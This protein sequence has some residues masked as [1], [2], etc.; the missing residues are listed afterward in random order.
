MLSKRARSAIEDGSNDVL[1]SAAVA[2]EI[3]IKH[4]LGK[5]SLPLD[6]IAYFP[7]RLSALGFQALAITADHAL[8]VGKLPPYHND[9]FDRIMIAQ[10]QMEGLTFVT[11]DPIAATYR[12]KTLAAV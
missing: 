4:A 12:L 5:L 3:T 6:P 9:P 7:A 1:V 8:A 11:K 2:W 10:A